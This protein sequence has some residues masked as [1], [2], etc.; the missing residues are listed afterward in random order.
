MELN[1][2][3]TILTIWRGGVPSCQGRCT[4]NT[5]DFLAFR[6]GVRFAL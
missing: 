1:Q 4:A 2:F 5:R 6:R 3:L